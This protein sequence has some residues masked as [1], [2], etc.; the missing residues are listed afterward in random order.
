MLAIA[1]VAAMAMGGA[2]GPCVKTGETA[3]T[4]RAW[5]RNADPITIEKK[6]FVKYG[7]PR[8]GLIQY[9]EFVQDHDGVPVMAE[10]GV[11]EHEVLYLLSD[12]AA[13]EFQPYQVQPR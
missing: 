4:A 13:C 8:A 3:G 6:R 10:K 1:L 2:A 12:A 9:L 11:R 5:Y 7:L